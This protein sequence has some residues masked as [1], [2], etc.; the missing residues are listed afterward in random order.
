MI[1]NQDTIGDSGDFM[2]DVRRANAER[3]MGMETAIEETAATGFVPGRVMPEPAMPAAPKFAGFTDED[4]QLARR[5]AEDKKLAFMSTMMGAVDVNPDRAAEAIRFGNEVG[6]GP[7]IALNDFDGVQHA[8]K[9]KRIEQMNLMRRFPILARQLQDQTFANIAHDDLDNLAAT[10]DVFSVVRG[11]PERIKGIP[12]GIAEGFKRGVATYE[13]A[14]LYERQRQSGGNLEVYQRAAI[15]SI[16]DEMAQLGKESGFW[17]SASNVVTLNLAQA[18]E[19]IE[20]AMMTMVA[21]G[22]AGGVAG[23]GG[24]VAVSGGVLAPVTA[25]TG[26]AGGLAAGLPAGLAAGAYESS[27]RLET[28]LLYGE[29][30]SAGLDHEASN[31]AALAGGAISGLLEV[32]GVAVAGKAYSL[33]LKNVIREGVKDAIKDRTRA[34]VFRT[35]GKTYLIGGAGEVGTEI[36][37]DIVNR[38]SLEIAKAV[39]DQPTMFDN[40]GE[41]RK[42]GGQL[43]D[44]ALETAMAMTLLGIPG[45]AV[46]F[47]TGSR[48]A[49]EA[50]RN[51]KFF[52]ALAKNAAETKVAPRDGDKYRAYIGN[53]V[54]GTKFETMYVDAGEMRT[55]LQQQGL[56]LDDADSVF[57]GIKAQLE[58]IVGRTGDVTIPTAVYAER[59]ARTDLGQAILPHV[60]PAPNAMSPLEAQQFAAERET[61][62]REARSVLQE[63]ERIDT[64]FVQE[65][66]EL[67]DVIRSEI[68]A[69]RP[70]FDPAVARGWAKMSRDFY[71]VLAADM[72]TT[73]K[74]LFDE[75]KLQR[76]QVRGVEGA[77][78]PAMPAVPEFVAPPKPEGMDQ[79]FYDD[80][81]ERAIREV[82]GSPTIEV[83]RGVQPEDATV[84]VPRATEANLRAAGNDAA[85]D[86]YIA[87]AQQAANR[88]V[89]AFQARRAAAV[90]AAAPDIMEQAATMDAEYMAAVERGDME[91]AQRMVDDVANQAE[92]TAQGFHGTNAEFTPDFAFDPEIIG[93]ANDAGFYGRGFYFARTYGEARSYGRNVGAFY[94]RMQNPLDLTNDTPDGTFPGHFKS[95]ASKLERIGMLLPAY[96]QALESRRKLDEYVRQNAAIYPFGDNEGLTA[97]IDNPV[98]GAEEALRVRRMDMPQT[99][100]E[101]RDAMVRQLLYELGQRPDSDQFPNI[102][103]ASTS[104]S[105]YVRTEGLSQQ[106]TNAAKA[107]GH[108]AI[109]YGDE[110][111]MFSP[112]QVKSAEPITRDESG[113]VIPLSR[114]FDITSPRIFEQAAAGPARGGFD[115]VTFI[116]TLG[117]N[118]DLTTFGH[119]A[120][121]AFF[122]MYGQIAVQPNAPQRIRDSFDVLLRWGSIAGATPEERI[123]TWNAL[124]FEGRRKLHES[125]AYNWEIYL[126][127]GK[128]PS[129]EMRDLFR[130]FS[131][132]IRRVYK[133]IREELT[134]PQTISAIYR[135]RY[136]EE[137]LVLTPEVRQVMDR[138]LAS[139]EQIAYREAVDDM[140]PMLT[141]R[142]EGM[143]DE[144]WAEYENNAVAARQDAVD[145][146]TR[147]SMK[148]MQ[149]LSR[150]KAQIL[151]KI[152]A[153][154]E[155]ARS[156]IRDEVTEQVKAMPVYRAM[157]YLR[158][159]K[160]VD[161]DGTE[162][163]TGGTHRLDIDL[164]RNMYELRERVERLAGPSPEEADIPTMESV[165]DAMRPN[166]RKLGTGKYGMLGSDGLAPDM[167][168]EM[169]GYAN[170]DIMVRELIAAKPMAEMIADETDRVMTERYGI[171]TSPEAIEIQVQEALHNE[172]R[173]RMVATELKFLRKAVQPIRVLTEA[174]RQAAQDIVDKK[175]IRELRPAEY[176][177]S[178][179]RAARQA[180]TAAGRP[181]DPQTAGKAAYTR[182]YNEQVAAGVSEEEAVLAASTALG[183]ATTRAERALA[184]WQ[185]KYGGRDPAEI[186]IRAKQ[187]QLLQNQLAAEA[188]KARDAIDKALAG[189]R[190]FFKPDAKIAETREMPLVMAARA[191]LAQ[192]GIG[193]SDKPA[194][195]Y[196]EQLKEYNPSIHESVSEI[197]IAAGV[198]DYRDMTVED[199][200]TMAEAVEALWV[201]AKRDRLIQ[202]GDEKVELDAAVDSLVGRLEEIGIPKE[203]PG[204]RQAIQFKDKS[205]RFA[206][207][208]RAMARRIESWSDA[209]DGKGDDRSFTK[210][211]YRIVKD[212][213]TAFKVRRNEQI[214]KMY[215]LV[216][217]L[218]MPE[219]KIAA[220]EINYTF[221]AGNAGIGK[222][223]LLGA[224]LHIGN[225]SNYRKLLVGRGWG[226]IDENGNL[227]DSR[228]RA[229]VSR[230][231]QQNMLTK[232]DFDF[233]QAVWD[234]NEE[235]KPLLQKAHYDLEGYYFKEIEADQVV[236]PFGTYRG[237]YVPAAT[238]K[239]MVADAAQRAGMEELQ[240]DWRYSLPSTGMGMTK[241]RVKGYNRP[242][243]LD[244]RLIVSHTDAALRFAMIQ[245]AI[246]DVLKIVKNRRFSDAMNRV[247]PEV[248][249]RLIL[250]WLNRAAKQSV[251]EAGLFR[252]VDQFWTAA[253]NR[254]GMSI[255]FASVRNAAQQ[256]VGL[257]PAA[258]KV[259]PTYL[260]NA[261]I[262]YMSSPLK[263]ADMVAALSPF[264]QDRMRSQAFDMQ[265]RMNE[266]LLNPSKYQKAQEWSRQ[267]AYFLQ[268][269]FQNPVDVITWLGAYNQFLAE[270]SA[271][272]KPEKAER[273]AIAAGDSAVRLTQGSMQ[274][275][276][277]ATI[278][279]GT[280]FFRT[281]TQFSGYFNAMGNLNATEFVKTMRDMGWR[282]NK[283]K[284]LYIYM[285]GI[286]A[287]AI[288]S[289]AIVRSLGG[290]WDDDDEDGYLDIAMDWFFGSQVRYVT[291][292]VPFGTT[293]YTLVTTAFDNKPYN[294]RMTTS[295]A[296]T[297]IEASTVGVG[298]AIVNAVDPDKEITGKNVRDVLTLVSLATGLPVSAAGR[299]IG[300]LVDVE[301]G[302]IEPEGPV[303]LVRGLLTGT[304]TPESKR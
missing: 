247:D 153:K 18:P 206:M 302:K 52:D 83:R 40:P 76:M 260:K 280:P 51:A 61:L 284:L 297:A 128:A 25:V 174:A 159:G 182:T 135:E 165:E 39:R 90:A 168:A 242:L 119:E 140:K 188:L 28:A 211:L 41:L 290:G 50:E 125:F 99:E 203:L 102:R 97:R 196:L 60:R 268:T 107:A 288:V 142:P 48:R 173:A 92:F 232:K 133:T 261:L 81:I 245:P 108:D 220:E 110:T 138:M 180:S 75:R 170:G 276:D 163:E 186:A 179:A 291:A 187:Q 295:P 73:P 100:Q 255:M 271:G 120:A 265:D 49:A 9:M 148:D 37:Q 101:A 3:R 89:A 150:A 80:L 106:L 93:S 104:L 250:P 46:Q 259:K 29:A 303:D 145:E 141:G 53:L 118:A 294:D 258:L 267:H 208:V 95:W 54:N 191:I 114:R 274:P 35:V 225:Q 200:R 146:L 237:G 205:A 293:G 64:A 32:A 199:F 149:W 301:R 85:A 281:F 17:E 160:L 79:A 86:V 82:G 117:K 164:V 123:A 127:E 11:I 20:M 215:E 63:K 91:T 126:F 241:A 134:V 8:A 56:T 266:I 167:V 289:D 221:G 1:D 184:Q 6:V 42:F 136:G 23:A 5:M 139:E 279:A 201:K 219:G 177:A 254:T 22:L 124:P 175:V 229:F 131:A 16:N 129:V 155:S 207:G 69:A 248:I 190:K 296:V 193:R 262:R 19:V 27:R 264:M 189:F 252:P 113:N 283:G 162:T 230:M 38:A 68:R 181:Q 154:N 253:R 74:A 178:E 98:T 78:A 286:M 15:Q 121:H 62:V 157:S 236:T 161:A 172:A 269:A 298:K 222:A 304:V 96:Q 59:G 233:L 31:A 72:N 66:Q 202:V 55:V 240:A 238:D 195:A 71:V 216:A 226:Q 243:A 263:T 251:S 256:V 257:F 13:L 223:E 273:E 227:D 192:R 112:E 47:H 176:T 169:F 194:A 33:A 152:Q 34:Q 228:W 70:D 231:I 239:F 278:E 144:A 109:V 285:L 282:G 300:Y 44:T 151:K 77:M 213:T 103:L 158:R 212:A 272:M 218:E 198:G 115:P 166:W 7:D 10:E 14:D 270:Q 235:I 132:W 299:P 287:P 130:K 156:A 26:L 275:E 244:L 277:I 197:V 137:L 217:K 43:V 234:L 67:E 111:I 58:E 2:A 246:A 171:M 45:A 30:R 24:G 214:K 224:M 21:S 4:A 143:S 116:L 185:D 87:A 36:T 84:G 88:N 94:L 12:Q 209:M 292:F 65:A 183:E 105:D 147:Q 122:E 57:P 210:L 204:E 249:Q